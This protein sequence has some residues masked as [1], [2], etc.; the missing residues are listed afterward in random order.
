[1]GN[2]LTIVEAEAKKIDQKAFT[3]KRLKRYESIVYKLNR[4]PSMKLKNMQD[5]G[6]C[7]IVV[8]SLKKLEKLVRVLRKRPEFKSEQNGIRQKNYIKDP[9]PDGYRGVHLIGKFKDAHGEE[10]N[11]EV[12]IRTRL[13]HDWATALEIVDLFTGQRLKSNQ[14]DKLWSEF[15]TCVS[16]QFAI[17]EKIPA[18]RPENSLAREQYYLENLQDEDKKASLLDVKKY[19]SRLE[20]EKKFIAFA[21]SIK[22]ADGQQKQNQIQGF[23]LINIDTEQGSIRMWFFDEKDTA[24]AEEKYIE[25][26]KETAAKPHQVVVLVSTTALGGLREAYPNYF[27]DSTEFIRYLMVI[28]HSPINQRGVT[29]IQQA[30][31]WLRTFRK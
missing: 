25:F 5:I 19:A 31:D 20:V 30:I 29:V 7:R 14:G 21:E 8:S 1:M 4:Y 24:L 2:A 23:V 11:I 13:Q 26:E 6:G 9:K 3:A 10:K 15:F 18:F 27:A 22:F 16:D 17:M 28:T 12:Q